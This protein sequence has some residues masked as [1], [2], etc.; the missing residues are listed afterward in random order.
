MKLCGGRAG[1]QGYLQGEDIQV[2]LS[3]YTILEE[4]TEFM[5]LEK[6]GPRGALLGEIQQVPPHGAGRWRWMIITPE[7]EW[8]W[9][10]QPAQGQWFWPTVP[11]DTQWRMTKWPNA[12]PVLPLLPLSAQDQK[13][14]NPEN[15]GHMVGKEFGM[16]FAHA[17]AF[18]LLF[19]QCGTP[20]YIDQPH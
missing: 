11:G 9:V 8:G 6:K 15:V 3:H 19:L 12:A 1:R 5:H 2:H 4:T 20:E 7:G 16:F 14:D 13:M 18:V 10:W 17:T